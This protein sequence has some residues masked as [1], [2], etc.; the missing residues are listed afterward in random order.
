MSR[1]LVENIRHEDASTDALVLDNAGNIQVVGNVISVTGNINSAGN[2]GAGTT[3]PFARSHIK[4]TSWSSGSPYGTVALIEGNNVNDNNWGHLVITDTTTANGNGGS[5][6]FATGASS[7]LNPFSGIQGTA[8]GASWGGI[9]LDTRPQ[10]GTA[11]RR[12]TIDSEGTVGIGTSDL[13]NW[14]T[15]F[16]GRLRLGATGFVGTTSASTQLGN[17]WRYNGSAYQRLTNDY[18]LRYYQNGGDHVWETAVSD[19]ADSSITWSTKMQL[20]ET[21]YLDLTSDSQIRLSLG[22]TG[23]PGTNTAN[24]IR[25]TGG[26]LGLNAASDN[27]HFEIGGTQMMKIAGGYVTTPYIPAFSWLGSRSH[28]IT[29]TGTQT[30]TSGNVWSTS[31]NHAFNNGSHFNASNGRFTAPVAGKY[32]F[33]FQC[34]ASDFGSGYLW[35]YMNINGSTKSYM[36]FNQQTNRVPM[37]HHMN[38]E[39]AVGDYVTCLWTN[40]YVSGQIH[41]P[42]F[43]GHL[44]G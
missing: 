36:Q 35:F 20:Q 37:V 24:W 23:T 44:I 38:C 30:M 14:S 39:L 41:Y 16:D 4:D 31:V 10:S 12:L 29:T 13:D 25:G 28:S 19:V 42:G 33:E 18:A 17:N 32:H 40:N 8:E 27:I 5:I 22:N 43:S 15:V 3:T 7:A 6:R 26:Q 34:M 21:G 2:I 1:L 11:T 9:G